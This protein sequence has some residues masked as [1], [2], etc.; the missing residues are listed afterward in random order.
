M[1]ADRDIDAAVEDAIKYD[2]ETGGQKNPRTT[3]VQ[4]DAKQVLG[5]DDEAPNS[6]V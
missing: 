6:R 4:T 1:K 5:N 3:N 2:Y